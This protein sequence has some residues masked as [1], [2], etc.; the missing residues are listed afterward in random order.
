MLDISPFSVSIVN[1]IKQYTFDDKKKYQ[2][3]IEYQKH[4][5]KQ[6]GYTVFGKMTP[7]EGI[8][9]LNSM[10]DTYQYKNLKLL[11][12]HKTDDI[13][14]PG[15]YHARADYTNLPD[16]RDFAEHKYKI[17]YEAAVD[18]FIHG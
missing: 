3:K 16:L 4:G 14:Q 12:W 1:M 8:G 15:F 5:T 6:K 17:E 10:K 18:T 11:V 13:N 2:W 9:Y 7:R